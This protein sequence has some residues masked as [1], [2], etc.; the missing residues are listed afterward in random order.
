MVYPYLSLF[1]FVFFSLSLLHFVYLTD[2]W[3]VCWRTYTAVD[4]TLIE[5]RMTKA[6]KR[7]KREVRKW[8]RGI[9]KNEREWMEEKSRQEEPTKWLLNCFKLVISVIRGKSIAE[10][11]SIRGNGD[12][13]C[14]SPLLS[15]SVTSSLIISS[16]LPL[17]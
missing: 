16:L 8:E 6:D 17:M 3:G 13:L 14:H 4:P 9:R 7:R 1:L 11:C 12:S 15:L 2:K 10:A 5:E